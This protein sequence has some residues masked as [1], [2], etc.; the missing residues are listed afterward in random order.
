MIKR[1]EG[2]L[3]RM[4]NDLV[5]QT[6]I[7]TSQ[8]FKNTKHTIIMYHGIDLIGS[9]EFNSRQTSRNDFRKHVLFLKK[10]FHIISLTDFFEERF[11]AGKPNISLTFDDGYLNNFKY[12]LPI[13]EETKTTG[14]FYITGLNQGDCDIL[15]ADFLDIA[16]K[17]TKQ[18]IEIDGET[19]RQNNGI[20]YSLETGKNLYTLIKTEKAES[21]YKQMMM[22]SFTNL[23][24]FKSDS[25]FD[26]YWK[27]MTDDQIVIC[28]KS[29]YIEIG[30]HGLHHNNLGSIPEHL[31]KLEL[32]D[33]KKYLE[34][35]IQKSIDS[36][37]YPDGSYSRRTLDIAENLGYKYQTAA[38]GFLYKEDQN[39][40]RIR[41]RDGIYT[42]DTCANQL[43]I[44]L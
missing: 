25:R 24:D 8:R 37:G 7:F 38:D 10:Y 34:N 20:Y 11:I 2:K 13:L 28:S 30:S 14:T 22:D 1:I 3:N 4:F 27:L 16:S 43:L 42:C 44:N 41:N 32:A 23:Y 21:N 35:I 29:R 6:G 15:W 33:S 40:S 5:F 31:A 12:A 39:D 36:I 19:F 9:T 17:L 26:D 18:D